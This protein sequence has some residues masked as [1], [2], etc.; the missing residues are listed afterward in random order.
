M[1]SGSPWLL[2]QWA[3]GALVAS[4]VLPL[5]VPH[6][7]PRGG[8]ARLA[9]ALATGFAL[10]A[11]SLDGSDI[12]A[13]RRVLDL[14]ALLAL[15]CAL[16]GIVGILL[17]DVFLRVV[18]VD[19]PSILRDVLQAGTA[20]VAVLVC[21]RL[22]GFDLLPLLTTSAVLTAIVGLALQAPIAN[23]FGGLA[24]QIDHTLG[25]G[26]WIEAGRFGGRIVEIGW[27]STQII[28]RDGDT[29]FIPNSQLLS[30]EVLNLSRPTGTHRASVQIRV[31]EHEPPGEVR[32]ALVAAIRDVPGVLD[33]PPP[34]VLLASFGEG[35]ITYEARYWLSE[36][37]RDT[38]IASDVRS[39][40]WYALRR[41]G[42]RLSRTA[43]RGALPHHHVEED[44]QPQRREVLR[45]VEALRSLDDESLDSLAQRMRRFEFTAG[46]TIFHQGGVG[47]TL[48]IIDHGE[49]GVRLATDGSLAEIARLRRGDL[50][51]EHALLTGEPRVASCVARSEVACYAIDRASFDDLLATHPEIADVLARL[52]RDRSEALAAQRDSIASVARDRMEAGQRTPLT[53][54]LR[55][56][57]RR[58]Q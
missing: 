52:S 14:A 48:Y 39:R 47:T 35:T 17:F 44:E 13:P 34:D 1:E 58:P 53:S 32:E 57:F 40:L 30:G 21:L 25:E 19:V 15:I 56:I 18:R 3:V 31:D 51:G 38:A 28:T 43:E 8:A 45:E 33:Y 24:L 23:L 49:V 9:A 29:L 5:V 4:L 6:R 7:R 2:L 41:S 36:F 12:E 27:R 37:D 55:D 22:A 54:R 46:E 16:I 11:V 42:L 26:D 10:A 20:A 50:F